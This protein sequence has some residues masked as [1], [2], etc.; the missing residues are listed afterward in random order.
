MSVK[1]LFPWHGISTWAFAHWRKMMNNSG[2]G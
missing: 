1:D 2:L